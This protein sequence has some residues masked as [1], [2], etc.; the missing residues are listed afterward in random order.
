MSRHIFS[1]PLP[2]SLDARKKRPEVGMGNVG[3][4]WFF[5]IASLVDDLAIDLEYDALDHL[6]TELTLRE[7]KTTKAST[8]L[9]SVNRKLTSCTRATGGSPQI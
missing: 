3:R 4:S 2:R 9:R 6:S 1:T 5:K 8:V 7:F